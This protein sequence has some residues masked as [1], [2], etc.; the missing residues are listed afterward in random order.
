MIKRTV[1]KELKDHLQAKEISL[2]TGPRQA[3]KT[4]LMLKL[5]KFLDSQSKNT[6]YLN[7]DIETDRRFFSSQIELIKKIK[8]EIGAKSGYVFI[9]EI[10]RKEN[11][12]LFLKGIYDMNLPYKFIVSGSGSLELKEKIHESLLGRKRIFE[13]STLSLAEFINHKTG[14]K[15]ENKLKDF[16]VIETAKTKSYLE[17]YLSFGGYPRIVLEEKAEEKTKLI[18]EI[19]QSF[20]EKDI[21]FLLGIKKTD[22]FGNLI[23]LTSSQIGN[24][25]KYSEVSRTLGLSVHTV[26]NYLWYLE[27]TYILKR[28][29]PFFK[30]PRKEI[31]KSPV[32]YFNDIGFRNYAHGV[33]GA[34]MAYNHNG[35][36]FENLV[37]N[38]LTQKYTGPA[39]IAYWRTKDKAEVDFVVIKGESVVPIE[40]KFKTLKKIELEKSLRSFISRYRPKEAYVINLSFTKSVKIDKTMVHFATLAEFI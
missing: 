8:L 15:Y 11:A 28:V 24:L 13:I 35:F 10:Q 37:Y 7:L 39:K 25:L 34:D 21:A 27:K 38:I 22:D 17:E 23:R 6:L 31:T 12:G 1:F 14:Y 5:K 40:V 19:Y 3:G 32:F 20:L 30:N 36:C 16:L 18:A 9:D 2:I 29:K 33:Y 26:K 4:T